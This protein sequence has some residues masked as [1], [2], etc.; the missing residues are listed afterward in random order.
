MCCE[1]PLLYLPCSRI[2]T[3]PK[4]T[5]IYSRDEPSSGLYLVI[6]GAVNLCRVARNGCK[7]AIHICTVD[8]FFG[9]TSFLPDIARSEEAIAL[10]ATTV[11]RWNA[12]EVEKLLLQKPK[13]GL[14]LVQMLVQRGLNL[15]SHIQTFTDHADVRLAKALL[16]LGARL[17][18]RDS[19][20]VIHM[21]SFTHSM[22][23]SYVGTSREVVTV[24]MIGFRRRGFVRYSR[25]EIAI[26]SGAIGNWLFKEG[27][28][29]LS[30]G[31]G[32][33]R[34]LTASTVR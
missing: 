33:V 34:S 9:E 25:K 28:R 1:D 26:D 10:E 20:G 21:R 11:M 31:N 5:T 13:L 15:A 32:A 8:D 22:L 3:Y 27:R 29:G 6:S 4:D 12:S 17:G 14:A 18:A 19:S 23:S 7:I 24:L 16:Y 2:V 30:R